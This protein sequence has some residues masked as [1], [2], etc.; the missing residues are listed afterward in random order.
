MLRDCW[1]DLVGAVAAS[2]SPPAGGRVRSNTCGSDETQFCELE[3]RRRFPF[4]D[5]LVGFAYLCR[6]VVSV[7]SSTRPSGRPPPV[8][9]R[10]AV[11]LGGFAPCVEAMSIR[12]RWARPH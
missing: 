8:T 6:A 7:R 11:R 10:G 9:F 12:T 1:L 2:T 5:D 4:D 3:E